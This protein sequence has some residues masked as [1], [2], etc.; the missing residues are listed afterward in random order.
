MKSVFQLKSFV[1]MLFEETLNSKPC[2]FMEAI[3]ANLAISPPTPCVL[4][5]PIKSWLSR[6]YTSIATLIRFSRN[7]K[8]IP[9][10]NSVF[11][12]YVSSSLPKVES[13]SPLSCTE[14][15]GRNGLLLAMMAV[16]LDKPGPRSPVN[17]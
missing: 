14:V 5:V 17:E 3:F 7:P 16:E 10:L 6:V 11:F 13:I 1:L 9:R 4:V 15:N 2:D 8:S 12:S